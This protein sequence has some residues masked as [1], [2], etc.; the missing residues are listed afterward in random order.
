MGFLTPLVLCAVFLLIA[1]GLMRL[2]LFASSL[3]ARR[4][5]LQA[6]RLS[7]DAICALLVSHFG[8]FAVISS[9]AFPCRT[10]NGP[11][12]TKIDCVLI[13]RRGIAVVEIIPFGGTIYNGDAE[14]WYR[15][16]ESG[17]QEFPNPLRQSKKHVAALT[18]LL[19]RE[20][21]DF[22]PE[23]TSLVIMPSSRTTFVQGQQNGIYALPDALRMLRKMNTGKGL[24]LLERIRLRRAFGKYAKRP[25]QPAATNSAKRRRMP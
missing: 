25:R 16:T 12:Y 8:G 11:S 3:A 9:K 23:L 1:Y 6:G 21:I 2:A 5:I 10:P 22:A 17:R 24:S 18:A 15:V 7:S 13:L 19:E 14:R 4:R 20:K